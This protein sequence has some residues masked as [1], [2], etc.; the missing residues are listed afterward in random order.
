MILTFDEFVLEKFEINQIKI[1]DLLTICHPRSKRE[2]KKIIKKRIESFKYVCD[3][4][5]IDVSDII[6]ISDLF[7][8][9][10]LMETYL[11]GMFLK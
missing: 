4:N 6:N 2:L 1:D 10:N 3:L 8:I 7:K 9:Q 5:D 11:N